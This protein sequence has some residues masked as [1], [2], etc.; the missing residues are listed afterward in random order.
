MG[1]SGWTLALHPIAGAKQA[2]NAR[3]R[4]VVS[5]AVG[6]MWHRALPTPWDRMARDWIDFGEDSLLTV[7]DR[8]G[9]RATA[10]ELTF[11]FYLS[12]DWPSDLA[13][14]WL[15]GLL[16]HKRPEVEQVIAKLG[17]T[18]A[19]EAW[20]S[21]GAAT[22]QVFV[23]H[24]GKI[25]RIDGAAV[26]W[27]AP[28]WAGETPVADLPP[29]LRDRL[30]AGCQ[31]AWCA[32]FPQP[33]DPRPRDGA[34]IERVLAIERPDKVLAPRGGGVVVATA[35]YPI[36]TWAARSDGGASWRTLAALG[37]AKR[38][39]DVLH[40]AGDALVAILGFS[41][42]KPVRTASVSTDG[43]ATWS[44]PAPIGLPEIRSPKFLTNPHRRARVFVVART[45][46]TKLWRSDDG[47]RTFD[48]EAVEPTLDGKPAAN[49]RELIPCGGRLLAQW[50]RTKKSSCELVASDDDGRTFVPVVVPD[51]AP[52]FGVWGTTTGDVVV[53]D[54]DGHARRTGDGGRTWA[55]TSWPRSTEAVYLGG[56][57]F[58]AER[59]AGLHV[60]DD[61]G[62]T[63][64]LVLD[65]KLRDVFP[66]AAD[67]TSCYVTTD[68]AVYRVVVR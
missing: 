6:E 38:N 10:T 31:C 61:D 16:A 22:D 53:H 30:A 59:D 55:T 27:E 26:R 35:G 42:P 32:R 39:V 51:L 66:D 9:L 15:H 52:G 13:D 5:K 49:I 48:G 12:V 57:W 23:E 41:S 3:V 29:E 68:A 2:T 24:D 63:W 18:I 14:H 60:S 56:R 58:V 43:G 37:H 17:F 46:P 47:G 20:P 11:W 44:A 34:M 19:P 25:G 21:V 54:R 8:D 40:D 1:S 62:A 7:Q 28:Q 67:P 45:R 50:E 4:S 33:I 64:R 65:G 36:H